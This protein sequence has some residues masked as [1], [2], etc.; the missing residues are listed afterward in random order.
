MF[1][2][3]LTMRSGLGEFLMRIEFGG[4]HSG[5][6]GCIGDQRAIRCGDQRMPAVIRSGHCVGTTREVATGIECAHLGDELNAFGGFAALIARAENQIDLL[7][8]QGD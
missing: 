3:G 2:D 8:G 6:V 1:D 4:D 7:L 5:G